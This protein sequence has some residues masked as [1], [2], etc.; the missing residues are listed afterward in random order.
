M[1][2]TDKT[3]YYLVSSTGWND[4][5]NCD[6]SKMKATAQKVPIQCCLLCC[7]RWFKLFEPVDEILK[8]GHSNESY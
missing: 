6:N 1:K 5:Q 4:I 7:T 2:P 8:C 3:V